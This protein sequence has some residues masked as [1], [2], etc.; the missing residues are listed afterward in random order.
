MIDKLKQIPEFE[1]STPLQGFRPFKIQEPLQDVEFDFIGQ[2]GSRL[3]LKKDGRTMCYLD[4]YGDYFQGTDVRGGITQIRPNAN[5][6]S[7]FRDAVREESVIEL[8]VEEEIELEGDVAVIS[9][10]KF[11]NYPT[12]NPKGKRLEELYDELFQK[13]YSYVFN[14]SKDLSGSSLKL[15][16]NISRQYLPEDYQAIQID[17]NFPDGEPNQLSLT[18]WDW[19]CYS[20]HKNT[21]IKISSRMKNRDYNFEYK[22]TSLFKESG[23]QRLGTRVSRALTENKSD[24]IRKKFEV[25]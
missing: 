14:I 17:S 7:D 22:L 3:Y 25:V 5:F 9:E 4:C 15:M 20:I 8:K 24:S 11:N 23:F 12:Y 13:G 10:F 16:E 19:K 6:I 18:N 21:W 2:E 1:I